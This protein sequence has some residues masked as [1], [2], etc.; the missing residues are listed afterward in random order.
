MTNY[1]TIKHT[2]LNKLHTIDKQTTPK[3]SAIT[4]AILYFAESKLGN[5]PEAKLISDLYVG[6]Y[7]ES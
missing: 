1:N 3:L 6:I 2:Y 7:R 4:A 5:M